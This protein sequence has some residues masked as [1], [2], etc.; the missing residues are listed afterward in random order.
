MIAFLL[1]LALLVPTWSGQADRAR[2]TVTD[3]APF[4]VRG[5]GF[6]PGE[7]V[8]LR[9]AAA[10]KLTRVVAAD[11]LGRFVRRVTLLKVNE[12][13]ASYFVSARGSMGSVAVLKVVPECPNLQSVDQ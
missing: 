4:T 9:L 1:A 11:A 12:T 5:T 7:H 8:T 13:C 3:T 10:N 2:I 6:R